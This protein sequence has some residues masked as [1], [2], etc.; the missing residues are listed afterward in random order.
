MYSGTGTGVNN[1]L[2]LYCDDKNATTQVIGWQLNQ[3]GQMGIKATANTN[4]SLYVNGATFITG[5]TTTGATLTVHNKDGGN[6]EVIFDRNTNANWKIINS[7][8]ILYFQSDYINKK[9]AY[10]SALTLTY[11]DKSAVFY[12]N[13]RPSENATKALG[14]S[15]YKWKSFYVGDGTDAT[16]TSTGVIQATGGIA[17]TKGGYFGG[18]VTIASTTASTSMTTGALKV[19]GGVG[20]AGQL[21]AKTVRVDNSVYFQYNSTNECLDVIF[22]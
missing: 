14:S 10:A 7:N 18:E 15:T 6:S 2:T 12:G 8:G 4:Y 13:V 16:S 5:N 17:V 11:N 22:G 1:A 21:N 9:D 20:V 19:S 3:S